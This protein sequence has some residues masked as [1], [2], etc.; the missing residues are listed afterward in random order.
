MRESPPLLRF[1]LLGCETGLILTNILTVTME[2]CKE[3]G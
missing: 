3:L 1:R 2:K